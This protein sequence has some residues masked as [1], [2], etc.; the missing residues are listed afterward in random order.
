MNHQNQFHMIV[1]ELE[2]FEENFYLINSN[3]NSNLNVIM[4]LLYLYKLDD[5]K[6]NHLEMLLDLE[7][8]IFEYEIK[9][10]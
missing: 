4:T 1:I 9:R 10:K 5:E 2:D 3:K 8:I 6:L 7:E